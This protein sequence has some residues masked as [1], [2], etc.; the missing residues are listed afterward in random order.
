MVRTKKPLKQ[1]KRKFGVFLHTYY[2]INRLIASLDLNWTDVVLLCRSVIGALL[3][4]C[5]VHF[6]I[7]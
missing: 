7:T 1:K 4:D 2:C 3:F 6:F 5:S